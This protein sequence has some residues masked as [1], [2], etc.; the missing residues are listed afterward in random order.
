[1]AFMTSMSRSS[2]HGC[3]S[4]CLACNRS[5]IRFLKGKRNYTQVLH[6]KGQKTHACHLALLFVQ[7]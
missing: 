1:M 3:F 6:D 4:A 5:T 2:N 7:A